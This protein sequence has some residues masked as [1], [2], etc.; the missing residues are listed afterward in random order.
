MLLTYLIAVLIIIYFTFMF[1]CVIGGSILII[2]NTLKLFLLIHNGKTT[3]FK[4]D[5][6]IPISKIILYVGCSLVIIACS[7]CIVNSVYIIAN[8]V[9]ILTLAI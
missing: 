7:Y 2:Y 8:S 3:V 4:K 6:L 1:L 5:Y 9:Y